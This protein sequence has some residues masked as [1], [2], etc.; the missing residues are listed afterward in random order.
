MRISDDRIAVTI[1]RSIVCENII[2]VPERGLVELQS[3]VA[4]EVG[5]LVTSEIALEDK[6]IGS[7]SASQ[8]IAVAANQYVCSISAC[9][10]LCTKGPVQN[11]S[12]IASSER[13]KFVSSFSPSASR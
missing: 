9:Q 10:M 7:I 4:V 3:V 6:L 13:S 2:D 11:T 12:A 5:N 8:D 1:I